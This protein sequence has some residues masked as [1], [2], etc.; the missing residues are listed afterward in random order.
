MAE[1]KAEL[2]AVHKSAQ[3]QI[4]ALQQQLDKMKEEHSTTLN[5]L[6]VEQESVHNDFVSQLSEMRHEKEELSR[7]VTEIEQ[8]KDELS[9][10]LV[11]IQKEL[12][13]KAES[14]KAVEEMLNLK[15]SELTGEHQDTMMAMQSQIESL[16]AEKQTQFTET[17]QLEQ[18]VQNQHG[19]DIMVMQSQFGILQK[20]NESL[21][22][23]LTA[24]RRELSNAQEESTMLQRNQTDVAQ[25]FEVSSA[26]MA[27]TCEDY[28]RQ[29]SEYQ[30]IIQSYSANFK[31][32]DA[33]AGPAELKRIL[34]NL[35][36]E[37]EKLL[38]DLREKDQIIQSIHVQTPKEVKSSENGK[39]FPVEDEER[40]PI[41]KYEDKI[42]SLT[43]QLQQQEAENVTMKNDLSKLALYIE[44]KEVVRQ[45][46][47]QERDQLLAD[48]R[49]GGSTAQ[50]VSEF[51]PE[52]V[53]EVQFTLPQGNSPNPTTHTTVEKDE[54]SRVIQKFEKKTQRLK[55]QHEM[56]LKILEFNLSEGHRL[57][58]SKIHAE[59]IQDL[60]DGYKTR[61][62]ELEMD[63]IQK[64][65]SLKSEQEKKFVEEMQNVRQ[66][67]WSSYQDQLQ[68]LR[69][70][71]DGSRAEP[72]VE[73]KDTE[74]FKELQK[75]NSVSSNYFLSI[76][77][78]S[79]I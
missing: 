51:V 56:E 66:E 20:E 2:A 24:N 48:G 3:I 61:L 21:Q 64:E 43:I 55:E 63:F 57:D 9:I 77:L 12:A 46:L 14:G 27:A 31:A 33:D 72:N 53:M 69:V 23:Q 17:A 22:L 54:L 7:N 78:S 62:E 70:N 26:N 40:Q 50:V 45:Q 71:T 58:S 16:E 6:R 68:G 37:K 79:G 65:H 8:E 34:S 60:E 59:I 49:K 19:N 1:L 73:Q 13:D 32:V 5:K 41:R 74:I 36:Q 76:L 25:H 30:N 44:E 11:Q 52:E 18:F 35:N 75:E 47:E 10:R 38:S 42:N 15:I 4:E 29:I 28:K 39:F 67:L